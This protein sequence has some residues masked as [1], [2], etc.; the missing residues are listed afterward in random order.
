MKTLDK[1]S[2][3]YD[4]EYFLT[5]YCLPYVFMFVCIYHTYVYT[6]HIHIYV[7]IHTCMYMYIHTYT[8]TCTCL[9][10]NTHIYVM[11][12][13]IDYPFYMPFHICDYY[14][15]LCVYMGHSNPVL[16]CTLYLY[17]LHFL[18]WNE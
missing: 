7:N 3:K 15:L 17:V 11:L 5:I 9:C 14:I 16:E 4:Q 8:C 1:L 12:E 2:L 18:Q 13:C 6:H 10:I